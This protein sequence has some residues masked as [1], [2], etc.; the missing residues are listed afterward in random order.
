MTE[1]A[2]DTIT[3]LDSPAVPGLIFRHFRGPGDHPGMIAARNA[4]READ[5]TDYEDCG[6]RPLS[7]T[8]AYRK[9]M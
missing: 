1:R 6:F 4:G 8:A 9:P 3:L 2:I 7:W 5:G